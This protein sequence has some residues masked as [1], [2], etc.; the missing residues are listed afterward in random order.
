MS[1]AQF[2]PVTTRVTKTVGTG[3][4]KKREFLRDQKWLMPTLDCIDEN[5]PA[6]DSWNVETSPEGTELKTPVY[7][8][9]IFD[10]VQAAISAKTVAIAKTRHKSG[11][12]VPTDWTSLLES[13]GGSAFMAQ[14]SIWR[15]GYEAFID[16]HEAWSADKKQTYKTYMDSKVILALDPTR[17]Q[18][19]ILMLNSYEESL[20]AEEK[21]AVASVLTSFEK[22]LSVE[23]SKEEF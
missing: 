16:S 6:P 17:K 9:P 13:A 4:N 21:A 23:A 22:A 11:A 7:E 14:R 12:E 3:D 19:V 20:T 2:T 18:A 8:N 5:L 15:Q 10:F 1:T